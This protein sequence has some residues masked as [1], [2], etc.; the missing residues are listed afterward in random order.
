MTKITQKQADIMRMNT[1]ELLIESVT[2]NLF[3]VAMQLCIEREFIPSPIYDGLELQILFK[4]KSFIN[5]D[6]NKKI[7][8]HGYITN[9]Y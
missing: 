7:I 6:R 1:A 8:S 4:D 2:S 5:F 9:T 3:R